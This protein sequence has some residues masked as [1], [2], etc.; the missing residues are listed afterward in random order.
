MIALFYR[1]ETSRIRMKAGMV[2]WALFVLMCTTTFVWGEFTLDADAYWSWATNRNTAQSYR[3]FVFHH[4]GDSRATEASNRWEALHFE[5]ARKSDSYNSS[6]YKEFL[7]WHPSS[8]FAA[9]IPADRLGARGGVTRDRPG[10]IPDVPLAHRALST[11][12]EGLND[13]NWVVRSDAARSLGKIG[14]PKATDALIVALRSGE[15]GAALALGDIGSK[16]AVEALVASLRGTNKAVRSSAVVALGCIGDPQAVSP[17]LESLND[18]DWPNRNFVVNALRKIRDVRAAEALY[19]TATQDINEH[20]RSEAAIAL[21]EICDKRALDVLLG[22]LKTSSV[23]LRPQI[24]STLG[25]L[26]DSRA[27]NG[28]IAGLT[29]RDWSVRKG[30]AKAMYRIDRNRAVKALLD[31]LK[32]PDEDIR[33]S[34]VDIFGEMGD[35]T[36]ITSLTTMLKGTLSDR[37]RSHV[38]DAL[39]KIGSPIVVDALA[40][41]LNSDV[42]IVSM[43]VGCALKEIDGT[44]ALQAVT[45]Q[46]KGA[47][48]V[49]KQGAASALGRLGGAHAVDSLLELLKDSDN[50]VRREAASSLGEIGDAR[51]LDALSSA[52]E[53]H[54]KYVGERVVSAIGEI[55]TPAGVE[56][57]KK[58]LINP[59][60]RPYA[61]R[62]LGEIRDQRA[63]D[64][65]LTLL[66]DP[67]TDVR[68]YA[69]ASLGK[70][71]G[72]SVVEAIMNSLK[73]SVPWVRASAVEALDRIGDLR[74][75]PALV[76]ATSDSNPSVR[77]AA[78]KAVGW[79]G[80]QVVVDT[81]VMSL[82]DADADVREE[83]AET[84][85][86]MG[87]LRSIPLLLLA[88]DQTPLTVMNSTSE[89]RFRW[90]VDR[91]VKEIMLN[92]N[93][94]S[95]GA[96]ISDP[97]ELVRKAVASQWALVFQ[98]KRKL[99]LE[100]AGQKETAAVRSGRKSGEKVLAQMK[101]EGRR[102]GLVDE[103]EILKN[104]LRSKNLE[105]QFALIDELVLADTSQSEIKKLL[106]SVMQQT[107]RD[108][109]KLK[110]TGELAKMGDP[111]ALV[112]LKKYAH[113]ED[114]I[115]RIYAATVLGN[116][117]GV[118]E[119][120]EELISTLDDITSE[121]RVRAAT[122]I[123]G[124]LCIEGKDG[125]RDKVGWE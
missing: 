26:G 42:G 73:D 117:V 17:L 80:G 54:D 69:V 44:P 86:Q 36:A 75:L 79:I 115:E 88:R 37:L 118:Q 67:N 103:L 122:A 50:T 65:L 94:S 108:T 92:N 76:A 8:R 61:A 72:L 74:A 71:G 59:F 49:Y 3:C 62:A 16:A 83:S 93:S 20:V 102:L 39:G 33:E 78:V 32:N 84:L 15:S 112:E 97:N 58:A 89:S 34:V 27:L 120:P 22:L 63:V 7:L 121:V 5:L 124:L 106:R 10:V 60:L 28:L 25:D 64:I 107:R 101:R 87:A 46:L 35:P 114:P 23:R 116:G 82:K 18:P 125:Q 96:I 30:A 13:T 99:L 31:T 123:L 68:R 55:G 91:A 14:G 11:L 9:Q 77:K 110:V 105:E 38:L 19:R 41:N 2:C 1:N 40:E 21:A 104:M 47:P 51:A 100:G 109:L 66:N 70:T 95:L 12:V 52:L 45:S 90:T 119:V 4:S 57:L 53:D 98:T 113:S 56:P 6:A 29:D 81:V 111:E 85:M 43:S 48:A 24:I